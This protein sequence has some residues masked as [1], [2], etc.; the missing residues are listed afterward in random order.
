M[1]VLFVF[2]FQTAYAERDTVYRLRRKVFLYHCFLIKT[3]SRLS[4]RLRRKTTLTILDWLVSCS[5]LGLLGSIVKSRIT[6][7]SH[8]GRCSDARSEQTTTSKGVMLD[9]IEE[10]RKIVCPFTYLL[11]CFL[12]RPRALGGV[13]GK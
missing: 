1:G 9:F 12:E 7:L 10:R 11:T 13:C 4:P 8:P 6:G 2:Y 3:S 5:M